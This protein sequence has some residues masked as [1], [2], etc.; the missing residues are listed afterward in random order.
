MV[1]MSGMSKNFPYRSMLKYDYCHLTGYTQDV[2]CK[3]HGYTLDYKFKKK[4]RI[5]ANNVSDSSFFHIRDP[6][7][8]KHSSQSHQNYNTS[9]GFLSY[10]YPIH[11]YLGMFYGNLHHG[12]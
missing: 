12:L 7:T 8:S 3:H 2:Y 1:P 4:G 11:S 6:Q 10:P 9:Q 5:Q